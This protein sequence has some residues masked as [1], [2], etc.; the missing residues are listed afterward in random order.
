MTRLAI[1]SIFAFGCLAACSD[2]SD[3]PPEGYLRFEP[4]PITV[5]P[6]ASGQW[7]Q[8]VSLPIDQDM[9]VID[10]IGEQGPTGH[11]AILYASPTSHAV[12][13]TRDWRATDQITDR[14]LGGVGGEGAEGLKLPDGA[15]F[16]IPTGFSLY[17]NVHYYNTGDEP[18]DAWS[19]LDVKLEPASTNHTAV[20][21]FG[22]GDTTA[23]A[24]ANTQTEFTF[25]CKTK[26]D[27]K[28][29]MFSNHMH[30]FGAA[31]HTTARLPSGETMMLKDD[32]TW[33]YEWATEPNF[34][35]RPLTDPVVLPAG[36]QLQTTCS[37]NNTSNRDL[38]FPDEMCAFFAF[39]LE[40]IDR[41]CAP[42]TE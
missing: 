15:V 21:F 7:I 42:M 11:H 38:S 18:V 31:V 28:F 26:Q 4:A 27:M 14:L 8:Y 24:K 17:M 12:G 25:A 23:I 2:A 6:G 10:V 13:T 37:W 30:E 32:P 29:V 19:R 16:R 9:D 39:H 1:T 5:Q 41:Q 3:G 36:T 34:D 20:G 40:P 22:A 33:R 35:R